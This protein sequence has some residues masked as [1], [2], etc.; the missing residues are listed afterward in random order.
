MIENTAATRSDLTGRA[1]IVTL[2]DR[3]YERVRADI[4]LGP[5]FDGIARVDWDRHLPK[6]YDFW[7]TVLFQAN[8]FRGNLIGTHAQLIPTAAMGRSLFEHWLALFRATVAELFEG[9]NA[10]RIVLSAENM[11]DVIHSKIHRLPDPR[12][13]PALLT[14][15]QRQRY[16]RYRGE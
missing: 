5:I 8:T 3:F 9:P 10:A 1:D 13:D 14:E 15:E 11:A 12:F 16:A 2:V 7:D 6:L 4:T